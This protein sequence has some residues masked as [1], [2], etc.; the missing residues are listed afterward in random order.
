[1]TSTLA[2]VAEVIADAVDNHKPFY[3]VSLDIW[4]A[5]DV[6]DHNNSLLSKI[7]VPDGWSQLNL[8]GE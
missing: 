3:V 6:V 5:F 4:K 8:H 1:M 2:A 7:F